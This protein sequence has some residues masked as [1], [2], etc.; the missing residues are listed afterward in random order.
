MSVLFA[1]HQYAVT[2]YDCVQ[3]VCDGEDSALLELLPNGLLNELICSVKCRHTTTAF[4]DKTWVNDSVIRIAHHKI[5]CNH[6]HNLLG[7]LKLDKN[8]HEGFVVKC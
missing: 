7:I 3:S 2:V 1:T 4:R 6:L 8:E 5:L